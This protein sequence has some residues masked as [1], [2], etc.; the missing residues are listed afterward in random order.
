MEEIKLFRIGELSRLA[1]VSARTI[2]Y[3]TSIGLI[4]PEERTEKNYRLYGE[5]TLGRLERIEEMKKDKYTLEEIKA[6]L[7]NWSKI[8]PEQ[9]ISLKLTEIQQHLTQLEREAKELEPVIKQLKPRQASK[10]YTQLTPQ[11]AACIEALMLLIN[12]SSLM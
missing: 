4:E 11:T 8:S 10:L 7:D 2:D 9:K 12:K 1:Q 5:E 3:Y 6:S